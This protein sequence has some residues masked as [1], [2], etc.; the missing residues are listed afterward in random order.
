MSVERQELHCH[1]CQR[2]VQF[3]LDLS[4]N[5]NH[6]LNCPNC[7]HE[8]CRVVKDGKI[9]DIRWDTRNGNSFQVS[10]SSMATT[11]TS[12]YDLYTNTGSTGTSSATSTGTFYV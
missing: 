11:T 4:L 6:V 1:E 2:Y 12:T 8:H 9:T 7:G 3:D 10:A 5:G